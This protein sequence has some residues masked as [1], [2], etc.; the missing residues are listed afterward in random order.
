MSTD[1]ILVDYAAMQSAQGEM[2][3]I[4]QQMGQEVED[5]ARQLAKIEWDGEDATAYHEHQAAASQSV[6]D[7]KQLL[8]DIS[9][10]VG[11]A[12]E[13]YAATERSNAASW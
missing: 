1:K 3:K 12:H 4:A 11:K 9:V 10:A 6:L 8:H 7:I 5:L 2:A 13:N